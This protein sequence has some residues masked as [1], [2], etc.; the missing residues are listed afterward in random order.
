MNSNLLCKQSEWAVID[1]FT[2]MVSS[3]YRNEWQCQ[4]NSPNLKVSGKKTPSSGIGY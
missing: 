2:C 3:Y 1:S 4:E